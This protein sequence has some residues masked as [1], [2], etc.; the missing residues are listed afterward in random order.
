MPRSKST[1]TSKGRSKVPTELENCVL[2]IVAQ[3]GPC[4]PYAVRRTLAE[5]KSSFWS[6]SAG[7]IYP[8]LERLGAAKLLSVEED[9]FGSRTRRRY[10]LSQSGRRALERWLA[11]PVTDDVAAATHDP[12][13]TR[14]FFLEFL[15]TAERRAFLDDAIA[16]TRAA[17]RVQHRELE[18]N[19]SRFTTWEIHGR[20][21]ALAE[22][23]ARRCWLER[24]RETIDAD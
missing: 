8:L 20:E 2:G 14:V 17:H 9:A 15:S 13:R 4:T 24:V 11:G 12:V 3:I 7:A 6:A 5:S 18:Q 1:A 10:R 19:R 22:L 23:D 21:G 16:R